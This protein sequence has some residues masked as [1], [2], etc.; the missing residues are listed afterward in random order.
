MEIGVVR[1]IADFPNSLN[2]AIARII[3]MYEKE[4]HIK[5]YESM[6]EKVTSEI[7]VR[8][9]YTINV[10]VMQM[11]LVLFGEKDSVTAAKGNLLLRKELIMYDI[12][13]QVNH[14]IYDIYQGATSFTRR[15]REATSP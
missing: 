2:D 4:Y 15:T 7:S 11:Q 6:A 9:C 3:D 1:A 13:Y 10:I 14:L 12:L 8:K 5:V